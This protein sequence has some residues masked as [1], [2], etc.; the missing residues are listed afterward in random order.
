MNEVRLVGAFLAGAAAPALLVIWVR[1]TCAATDVCLVGAVVYIVG[2]P[3]GA[4][5]GVVAALVTP[6]DEGWTGFPAAAIGIPIGIMVTLGMS[7]IGNS[8]G[9]VLALFGPPLFVAL[10]LA[11]G[12]TR[13]LARAGPPTPAPVAQDEPE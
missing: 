10:G 1:D 12:A 6:R 9:Q 3:L 7:G 4:V 13:F 11:Y 8:L 5:A 2:A